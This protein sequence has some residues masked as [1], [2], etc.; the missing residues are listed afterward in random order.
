MTD[1][2]AL[3]AAIIAHPDEDTPRLMYADWL[4]ENDRPERAEFI[5]LQCAVDADETADARAAELEERNR[6][7]WLVGLP[8]V[9]G[10]KWEFNRG[11][12]EILTATG[13][14]FMERYEAFVRVPWVRV[15]C[16]YEIRH[17]TTQGLAD[18]RPWNP[19]WV[20]LELQEPEDG[21]LSR[22]LTIEALTRCSQARQLRILRLTYFDLPP[23]TV[24]ALI[25]SPHLQQL[26]YLVVD[27]SNGP[28]GLGPLR[29]RFG[30]RLIV[31]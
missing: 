12:P 23:D 22:T 26:R 27:Q 7:K 21:I 16:L 11:F 31:E 3:L 19:N 17:W 24:Q 30:N 8:Q 29:K 1:E 20:E 25:D 28:R 15:L 13:Q 4:D 10:A 5:R 6:G 2:A 14:L 9:S 18:G